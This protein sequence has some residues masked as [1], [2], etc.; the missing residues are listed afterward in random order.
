MPKVTYS[1]GDVLGA[2]DVNDFCQEGFVVNTSLEP[3]AGEPGGAWLAYTPTCDGISNVTAT[4]AYM[5]LGKTVFFRAK[6]ELTGTSSVTATP[7][8]SLPLASVAA[9][10]SGTFD[11]RMVDANLLRWYAGL[12]VEVNADKLSIYA[13]RDNSSSL[14]YS[15]GIAVTSAIPFT[16]TD[17]D[18]IEVTGFYE[19]S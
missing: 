17:D 12:G 3:T 1:P 7:E 9:T 14:S 10:P 18:Y 8:V 2:T 6:I 4:G 5:K 11:V 15:Y 19:T 13:L 16:W